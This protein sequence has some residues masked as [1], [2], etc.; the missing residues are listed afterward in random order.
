MIRYEIVVATILLGTSLAWGG[1]MENTFGNTVVSTNSK[2]ASSDWYFNSD[3]TYTFKTA[4]GQTSAGHWRLNGDKVCSTPD[5]AAGQP[6]AAE[7]CV[8]YVDGKNVGDSWSTSDAK[9]DSFTVSIKP[10]R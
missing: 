5:A 7:T 8:A 4:D 1:T 10:G 9:G 3:G 2:G 6:A